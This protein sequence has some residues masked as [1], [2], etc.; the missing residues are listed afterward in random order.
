MWYQVKSHM[1][2]RGI[3]SEGFQNPATLN[4]TSSRDEH[5][6]L[7]TRWFLCECMRVC[8]H[9]SADLAR[10]ARPNWTV[11]NENSSFKRKFE[12]CPVR[13]NLWGSAFQ[14]E[15]RCYNMYTY[16]SNKIRWA[17]LPD[18][19]V[20]QQYKIQNKFKKKTQKNTHENYKY[21]HSV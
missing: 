14:S 1:L 19:T 16:L 8:A 18:K 6:S 7:L 10:H 11:R 9:K 3:D 2:R 5:F 4:G 20:V 17:I 21:D 12:L 15:A 13:R